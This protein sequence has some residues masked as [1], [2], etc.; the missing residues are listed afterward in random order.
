VAAAIVA[1]GGPDVLGDAV[2]R[3]TQLLDGLRLKVRVLLQRRIQIV[4]VCLVMLPVMNL[5]RFRIDVRLECGEI[6]RQLREFVRHASSSRGG[7]PWRLACG[8][9]MIARES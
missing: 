3:A 6:V 7:A 4:H 1:D 5:H 9:A 2:D 8:R